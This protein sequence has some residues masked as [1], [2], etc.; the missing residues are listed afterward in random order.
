MTKCKPRGKA[1]ESTYQGEA[2]TALVG[3]R[4]PPSAKLSGDLG[5]IASAAARGALFAVAAN[6]ELFEGLDPVE[7]EAKIKAAILRSRRAA[8]SK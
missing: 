4:V 8:L 6:P 3:L 5:A 2:R 7:F 1:F